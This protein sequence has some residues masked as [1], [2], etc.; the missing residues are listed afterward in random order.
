MFQQWLIK[1]IKPLVG[2]LFSENAFGNGHDHDRHID[3]QWLATE[4][5]AK[6]P[7]C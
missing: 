3:V 6:K 4:S 7:V 2:Q 5:D 1:K